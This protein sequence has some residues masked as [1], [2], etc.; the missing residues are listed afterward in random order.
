MTKADKSC[1]KKDGSKCA[2]CAVHKTKL[3]LKDITNIDLSKMKLI[4]LG[5]DSL[6]GIAVANRIHRPS[7][8]KTVG[9]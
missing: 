1:S 2:G 3:F 5:K 7:G 8:K 4:K 6:T 9:D